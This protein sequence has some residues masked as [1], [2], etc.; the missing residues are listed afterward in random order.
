MVFCFSRTHIK[1]Q[2]LA[3]GVVFRLAAL[4]RCLLLC[5]LLGLL[6][7]LLFCCHMSI[8]IFEVI[9]STRTCT[10]IR[11]LYASYLLLLHS[12]MRKNIFQKKN[13]DNFF[14]QMFFFARENIFYISVY[15]T[16]EILKKQNHMYE[17][18]KRR[19]A[20]D[21]CELQSESHCE[22]RR[23]PRYALWSCAKLPI[24]IL[25]SLLFKAIT[26]TKKPPFGGFLGLSLKLRHVYT[27]V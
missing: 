24:H 4:F 20:E 21:G 9:N 3:R 25:S 2:P 19:N 10:S 16:L 13:V 11:C 18:T 17:K 15:P 8:N 7:G 5:H 6:N 1:K 27:C 14:T 22:C 23:P 12:F 26:K